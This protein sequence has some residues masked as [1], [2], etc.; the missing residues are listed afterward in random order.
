MVSDASKKKAAAKKLAAASKRGSKAAAVVAATKLD[1]LNNGVT[2][3][4]LA[5]ELAAANITDRTCTGILA[6]HAQSRDIHVSLRSSCLCFHNE[7]F[8]GISFR[9]V[10]VQILVF[11]FL[12]FRGNHVPLT[13]II[14]ASIFNVHITLFCMQ[15]ESL[16]V[17][18]HGHELVADSTLELNYGR[19]DFSFGSNSM[20]LY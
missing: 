2:A 8:M 18:F 15:I 17:T 5:E 4:T 6:S 14:A 20:Q 9:C 12:S 13:I 10:L 16:S 1:D 7:E 3:D 11:I 19:Y